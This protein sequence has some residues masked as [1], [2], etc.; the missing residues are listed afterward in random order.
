MAG[1]G[2]P[3]PGLLHLYLHPME[4]SPHPERALPAADALRGLVPDA[5]HLRPHA[6]PH[7]RAVRPLPRRDRRQPAGHRRRPQATW[8]ATA[9]LNFYTL[10]RCHDH[11]FKIY[12]AMFL[13]QPEPA[14]EAADELA[15]TL[16]EELLRIE[17]PPMADWLEGFVPMRLHVLVRFGRG[18]RSCAEPLPADP[19]LYCATDG[20]AALR[21]GRGARRP[22]RRGRGRERARGVPR[23]RGARAGHALPLQ[24]HLPRHPHRGER[25]AG[26]RDRLPPRATST[27]PSRTCAARSSSTTTCPTTSPGAG[28]SRRAT[29][30]ARCCSSRATSRRPRPSTRRPR[31]RRHARPAVPA[32]RQRLEPARL[33]RVPDAAGQAGRGRIVAQQLHLAWPPR[34]CPCEPRASAA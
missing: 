11:H 31:P 24:Q 33:P 17:V 20:D 29:R 21:Q 4:M 15:A 26:R 10:Y 3:H 32:P 8:S 9:P 1:R 5:G 27:R 7:R 12:G 23:G 16:T 6:D 34:R 2:E 22:G 18:R 28:C 19:E 30:S 25:D 13:G 14:L